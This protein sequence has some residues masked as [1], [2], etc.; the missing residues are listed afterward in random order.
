MIQEERE[1]MDL[2]LEDCEDIEER[3]KDNMYYIDKEKEVCQKIMWAAKKEGHDLSKIFETENPSFVVKTVL[4]IQQKVPVYKK[5]LQETYDSARN[6]DYVHFEEDVDDEEHSLGTV[7]QTDANWR[8][9]PFLV[10]E[11]IPDPRS[12][13]ASNTSMLRSKTI[14][15]FK[16]QQC[17]QNFGVT[18]LSMSNNGDILM[19]DRQQSMVSIVNEKRCLYC[20]YECESLPWDITSIGNDLIAVTI[21]GEKLVTILQVK[22]NEKDVS[23]SSKDSTDRDV[24]EHFRIEKMNDIVCQDEC[25]GIDFSKGK[26]YVTFNAWMEDPHVGYYELN[27]NQQVLG[28]PSLTILPLYSLIAP[29]HIACDDSGTH[30]FISDCGT[31]GVVFYDNM[32]DKVGMVYYSKDLVCPTG[33][34]LDRE[35]NVYVCC[36]DSETVHKL[37]SD[38]SSGDIVLTA[39]DGIEKPRGICF[40][41]MT[42][43]LLIASKTK[44][45]VREYA[46]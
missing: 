25:F 9:P 20:T 1:H 37:S 30:V 28:S 29:Q 19:V 8:L 26:L 43:K 5:M 34:T 32:R 17:G 39:E 44:S 31:H 21:P 13:R 3:H 15:A 2:Q 4:K 24:R 7:R 36:R 6:H 33:I 23:K 46:V 11:D 16:S 10:I 27:S 22:E 12:S 41:K 40:D 14:L 38:G 18:G 45:K 42:K 35:S